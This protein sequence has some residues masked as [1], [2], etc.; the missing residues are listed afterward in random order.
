MACLN[1]SARTLIGAVICAHGNMSYTNYVHRPSGSVVFQKQRACSARNKVGAETA[2]KHA[3]W[4]GGLTHTASAYRVYGIVAFGFI[5]YSL[6]QGLYCVCLF[7]NP[8][9]KARV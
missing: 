2:Q 4:K 8:T 1:V 3:P 7:V 6:L 9:L 5:L